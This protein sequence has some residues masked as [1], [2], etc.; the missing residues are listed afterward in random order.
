MVAWDFALWLLPEREATA[1]LQ[2]RL[3]AL[4]DQFGAPHFAPHV[5]A[6][7]GTAVIDDVLTAACARLARALAPPRLEVSALT[8]GDFL[9]QTLFLAL[10]TSAPLALWF[11]QVCR[12]LGNPKNYCLNPHLSL[13]Y[14][15]LDETAKQ[16]LAEQEQDWFVRHCPRTLDFDRLA[17]VTPGPGGWHDFDAWR[18]VVIWPLGEPA[19]P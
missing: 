2:P 11:E 18:E 7:G 5:T 14:A 4:A 16:T 12:D 9:F 17:L 10:K 13:L 15:P 6:Y 3:D 1:L 8:R 19:A